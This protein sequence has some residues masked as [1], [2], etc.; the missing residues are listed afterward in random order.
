MYVFV[1][2]GQLN[3]LGRSSSSSSIDVGEEGVGLDEEEGCVA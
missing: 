3:G 2:C 1:Q